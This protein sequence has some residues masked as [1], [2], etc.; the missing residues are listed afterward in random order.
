[1]FTIEYSFNPSYVQDNV[2]RISKSEHNNLVLDEANNIIRM[3]ILPSTTNQGHMAG[4]GIDTDVETLIRMNSSVSRKTS[5]DPDPDNEGVNMTTLMANYFA[6]IGSQTRIEYTPY[7]G[8]EAPPDWETD[9][10]N[11]YTD[12]DGDGNYEPVEQVV[13]VPEY[14]PDKTYYRREEIPIDPT[15][16]SIE[17]QEFLGSEIDDE[18]W[19][20]RYSEY[21]TRSGEEGSY[22]YTRVELVVPTKIADGKY[23]KPVQ[24]T[25]PEPEEENEG[26]DTP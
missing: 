20:T 21:Y 18:L 4:D 10:M 7:T 23:Y 25:E 12:E 9:Y 16:P 26:G 14:D 5:G 19:L 1:M 24:R 13:S 11:Y 8:A 6:N 15:D 3:K 2:I 17:W 22:Q